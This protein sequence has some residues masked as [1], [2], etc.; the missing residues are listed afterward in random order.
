MKGSVFTR[1]VASN[2]RLHREH[3]V[4]GKQVTRRF[5]GVNNTESGCK[6][7]M[8]YN[9]AQIFPGEGQKEKVVSFCGFSRLSESPDV[10]GRSLNDAVRDY[11]KLN[12]RDKILETVCFRA[13][14]RKTDLRIKIISYLDLIDA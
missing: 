8:F 13:A 12:S 14:F 1:R 4:G 2:R 7:Q 11:I 9:V 3:S 10:T 6:L 5:W